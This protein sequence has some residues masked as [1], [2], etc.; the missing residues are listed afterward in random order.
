MQNLVL[1]CDWGTSSFRLKLVALHDQKVLAEVTSQ[2]GIASVYN[3][4][5]ATQTNIETKR[6][7][8]FQEFLKKNLYILEKKASVSLR[9]I[10]ILISGM[11]SSSIGM[12]EL[13][14]AD[15]PFHINGSGAI[16]EK[17][18][19]N[20][21][22]LHDIFIISG[23]RNEHDVMRGEETQMV[24]LI[25]HFIDETED[26]DTLSI[27]PGTHS[28]HIKVKNSKI[29]GFKT[30]MTGEI[31]SL[32]SGQSI[33]KDTIEKPKEFTIGESEMAGFKLG[34]KSAFNSDLL[35]SLFSVR[36]NQLFKKL[37]KLQNYYYL[38]GLLIGTE[39]MHLKSNE[40]LKIFLCSGSNIFELYRLTLEE[41][42]LINK[43]TLVSPEVMDKAAV[44][45]QVKIFQNYLNKNINYEE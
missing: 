38:S 35:S 34:V 31:F 25:H 26:E 41:L 17:I 7:T 3:R 37:N 19:K 23:V 1:S 5:V 22:F 42:N 27:F 15:L 14:Y 44:A 33:L 16:I 2:E 6:L 8:F 30:F 13:A 4:W 24:G 18:E 45:G 40:N 28:K 29:A 10:P 39:L 43:T 36:V 21:Y 12:K 20:E 32:M 11:A 9:L